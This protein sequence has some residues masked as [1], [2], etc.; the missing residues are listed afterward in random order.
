M[1]YIKDENGNYKRTVRCGHCWEIG[2]NKSSCKRYRQDLK[3]SIAEAKDRLANTSY[4]YERTRLEN[5]ISRH[6]QKLKK[7]E[8]KGSNRKCGY[9]KQ[10]GHTRRTCEVRKQRV[11]E[12]TKETI[13]VRRRVAARMMEDGYAP[14]ALVSTRPYGLTESVPCI[15]TKINS[16]WGRVG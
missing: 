8:T 7:L 13:D 9:C 16:I 10:P 6:E 12:V 15:I 5:T 11:A 4:T 1:A 2:H 14:G 3:A